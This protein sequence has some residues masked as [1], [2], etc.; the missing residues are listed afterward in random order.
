M[1]TLS[2]TMAARY[3]HCVVHK[4][5]FRIVSRS[6]VHLDRR[7]R[8]VTHIERQPPGRTWQSENH[9]GEMYS[10]TP[11]VLSSECMIYLMLIEWVGSNVPVRRTL[12]RPVALVA[13][14]RIKREMFRTRRPS[15]TADDR[16]R[17]AEPASLLW[18]RA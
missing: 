18:L 2:L 15:M 6:L 3:V 16:R 8:G 7:V 10:K 17:G 9:Q 13:G 4:R 14:S 12:G 1:K 5:A 11:E